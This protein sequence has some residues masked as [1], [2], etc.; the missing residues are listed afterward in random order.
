MVHDLL[1]NLAAKYVKR[2][3]LSHKLKF[4]DATLAFFFLYNLAGWLFWV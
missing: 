1:L 2:T 4:G 3:Q